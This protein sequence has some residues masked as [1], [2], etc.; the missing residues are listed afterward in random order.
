[1]SSIES[2]DN[3][4]HWLRLVRTH[5]IGP[6]AIATLL[7]AFETVDKLFQAN[8]SQLRSTGL[9]DK[10]IAALQQES[11]LQEVEI[12]LDWQ[13]QADDRTIISLDSPRTHRNWQS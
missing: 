11:T 6:K 7:A 9:S 10:Q 8:G 1:V 2:N 4:V 3:L 13:S 12:D 5:G